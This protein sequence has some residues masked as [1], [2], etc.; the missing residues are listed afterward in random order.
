MSR[1]VSS[2]AVLG[3]FSQETDQV[4]LALLR[5][6]HADLVSPIYVVNNTEDITSNGD[7]YTAFPFRIEF[8]TDS[9]DELVHVVLS[10]DNVDRSIVEAI[11]TCTSRPSVELE[12]VLA[13]SPNTIEAGPFIFSLIGAEYNQFVVSG[14]LSYEDILNEPYPGDR[15]TP[16]EFFG[17]F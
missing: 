4:Y 11:R 13:A 6:D 15:F 5:L 16:A 9:G 3:C 1:S 12:I 14:E 10:I 8:P 17:L 7:L 2:A